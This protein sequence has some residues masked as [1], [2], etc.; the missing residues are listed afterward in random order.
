M[1]DLGT[2]DDNAKTVAMPAQAGT[3]LMHHAK[4]IHWAGANSSRTRSRRALGFIYYAESTRVDEEAK[5]AYQADLDRR[6]K[7]E[8][9]I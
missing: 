4:T 6:L 3:L 2:P 9:R 5:A 7:E 8:G 1:T